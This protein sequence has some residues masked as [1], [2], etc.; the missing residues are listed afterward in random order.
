MNPMALSHFCGTSPKLR[1]PA[2]AL[3]QT[4]SLLIGHSV[5]NPAHLLPPLQVLI[6][7]FLHWVWPHPF[8]YNVTYSCFPD[9]IAEL[10][11][12]NRLSLKYLQYGL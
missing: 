6:S 5:P 12:C 11:S 2:G 7:K 3:L 10:N 9:T 1:A 4:R 8:V